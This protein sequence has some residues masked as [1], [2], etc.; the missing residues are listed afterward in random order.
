VFLT[1]VPQAL[2]QLLNIE[3][4]LLQAAHL[5][6]AAPE[7]ML[8]VVFALLLKN[9]AQCSCTVQHH[10]CQFD[11]LCHHPAVGFVSA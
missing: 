4:N 3:G 1:F 6:S 10:F 8:L 7:K 5:G 11:S 2:S 9:G